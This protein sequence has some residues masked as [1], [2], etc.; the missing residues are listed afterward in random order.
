MRTHSE[1]TGM[2]SGTVRR[3]LPQKI[4]TE[5]SHTVQSPTQRAAT[6]LGNTPLSQLSTYLN[7]DALKPSFVSSRQAEQPQVRV[8]RI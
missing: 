5:G 3:C 1:A 2:C 7:Q 4:V 8:G 6:R